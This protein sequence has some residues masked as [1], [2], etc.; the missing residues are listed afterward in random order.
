MELMTYNETVN[1][2]LYVKGCLYYGS[3][4]IKV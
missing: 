2:I 4:S 1:N 3:V